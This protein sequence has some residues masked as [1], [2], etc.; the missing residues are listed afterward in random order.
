M[1]SE[2]PGGDGHALSPGPARRAARAQP[3]GLPPS[4]PRASHLGS[5][6]AP[7][8]RARPGGGSA[9]EKGARSPGD[10]VGSG[11]GLIGSDSLP[12][13]DPLLLSNP[14]PFQTCAHKGI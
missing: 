5:S 8:P 7:H 9:A 6:P 4:G 2:Q 1:S 13:P 14:E 12:P 10:V 3:P 11:G